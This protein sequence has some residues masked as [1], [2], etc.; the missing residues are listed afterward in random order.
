MSTAPPK[1]TPPVPPSREVKAGPVAKKSKSFHWFGFNRLLKDDV[2]V[3]DHVA[4][5]ATDMTQ[6]RRMIV[7]VKRQALIIGILVVAIMI[8]GPMV[9]GVYKFHILSSEHV[10]GDLTDLDGPVLTNQAILSWA[11]NSI[12]EIFTV[13][14]GNFDQHLDEQSFRFTENGWTSF[15][16]ALQS[17]GMRDNFRTQQLV[18]TTVPANAAVITA[19]GLNTDEEYQWVVELPII[20]TYTTNNEKKQVDK[21]IVRLNIIRVAPSQSIGG[22]AIKSLNKT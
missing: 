1:P 6:H 3:I 2:V 9:Q 15:V 12:T 8:I 19:Q 14:F 11:T 20:M 10:A 13:G 4:N 17:E 5:E 21:A 22:L 18:L 7:L 16:K